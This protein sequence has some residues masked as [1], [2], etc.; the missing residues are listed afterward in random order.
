[1]AENVGCVIRT[2]QWC[3]VRTLHGNLLGEFKP[4]DGA[5]KNFEAGFGLFGGRV[6]FLPAGCGQHPEMTPLAGEDNSVKIFP[7]FVLGGKITDPKATP[8]NI[9]DFTTN[10][11]PTTGYVT[12]KTNNVFPTMFS[13]QKSKA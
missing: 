5:I 13:S 3:A 9:P 10:D 8:G 1:M 7:G 2:G 6:N 12:D 11:R 4:F